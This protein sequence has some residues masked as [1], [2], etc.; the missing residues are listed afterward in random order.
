MAVDLRGWKTGLKWI[1]NYLLNTLFLGIFICSMA[2]CSGGSDGTQTPADE[3]GSESDTPIGEVPPSCTDGIQN[4]DETGIDCGGSCSACAQGTTYY[5]SNGGD[6]NDDGLSPDTAWETISRVND[7]PTFQP[8]DAILFR[9]G[10]EWR[11][12]LVIAWSGA[13]NAPILFGACGDGAKPRVL[14]SERAIDWTVVQG[15]PNVWRSATVLDPPDAGHASS[16]FFGNTDGSTSWGRAQDIDR[17]NHC[18][19]DF[20]LLGQEY[21][22]CWESDA[23]YV[24]APADPTSRYTFVEV[25]QRRGAITMVS[26]DPKEYIT[27]DGF[28]MMYGTMYGYNDGWPMDYEVRGLT[29]RNCHVG[30]IGIRGGD[31]A[32]GLVVWHSDMVVQNNDIRDCGRRSISYNVY[33]DVGKNTPNLVFENVLFENNVLHNGYH[34]TGFDISHGDQMFDTFE[35]FTFRNNFIWDDPADDPSDGLNDF[36]SMGIYLW[37]GAGQFID[38]KVYNNILK[39]IKQKSIA[40]A[41][42]DNLA[43]YNNT[44]YGMN[45][46]IN[47][48]R[49]M[50]SIGGDNANFRFDNNIV[51]GTISSDAFLSRCVYIDSGGDT[52]LTSMNNNLYFQDDP[53]Q[54]IHYISNE[55]YRIAD[56]DDYRNETGWDIDSPAPQNPRFMDAE[57][58]DFRLHSQSPAINNG[59]LIPG[60]NSV[61]AI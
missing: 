20:D 12:E 59:M 44:I 16:I 35:N 23:I 51:H 56:W 30:Y 58:D 15:H 49:P 40:V 48:Y 31:S 19:D 42:I 37:S 18:G 26:H 53:G 10:D 60:R 52:E 39:H 21:D 14:G 8:G 50:V 6:D 46:N 47:S 2:A 33:T 34:T 4:Q 36:T 22:W 27:I 1:R 32:M 54:V 55:S 5:I 7:E 17:V 45:P 11:E 29:I 9:R 61:T 24:Y 13:E 38:F 41:G 25:P 28:E 57:Y 3:A 43:I